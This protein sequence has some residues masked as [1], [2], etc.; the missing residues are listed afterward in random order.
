MKKKIY[1]K[2]SFHFFINE[3]LI[4]SKVLNKIKEQYITRL[5]YK[6]IRNNIKEFIDYQRFFFDIF[7][8]YNIPNIILK[9]INEKKYIKIKQNTI[10]SKK[11]FQK[12]Y[13]LSLLIAIVKKYITKKNKKKFIEI[14]KKTI[15]TTRPTIKNILYEIKKIIH[16]NKKITSS[17]FNNIYISKIKY[18]GITHLQFL[19]QITLKNEIYIKDI[20]KKMII[21]NLRLVVSIAKTFINRGVDLQDLIQEGS[22]GLIKAV[23]KYTYKKG[24]KFS[25]YATWWIRQAIARSISDQARTIRVPVHMIETINKVTLATKELTQ[26]TNSEISPK[27]ISKKI[28]ISEEQ[29]KKSL[30]VIQDPISLEYPIGSDN[31]STIKNLIEDKTLQSPEKSAI[32]NNKKEIIYSALNCLE[33]RES[34]V[35]RMRFGIGI[36]TEHT[37]E[38]IGQKLNVTRERIRQI[39]VKALIKLKEKKSIK[40]LFKTDSKKKGL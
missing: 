20:K 35:L 36:Y 31:D 5:I 4:K 10:L 38:E 9:E 30:E 2:N 16:I 24:F 6:H 11:S 22:I 40:N 13:H 7:T 18:I 34:K 1:K 32:V 28:N 21:D 8:L 3:M 17:N 33:E 15:D 12:I 37:L 23:E 29:I 39:E 19:A 25:T 26:N 14:F 27:E